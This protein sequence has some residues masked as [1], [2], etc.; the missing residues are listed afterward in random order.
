MCFSGGQIVEKVATML[1][2]CSVISGPRGVSPHLTSPSWTTPTRQHTRQSHC[3]RQLTTDHDVRE[4][5]RCSSSPQPGLR[6]EE[7]NEDIWRRGAASPD[8]Q[9]ET[10]VAVQCPGN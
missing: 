9:G 2:W 10:R 3:A 1:Y 7:R 6:S 5:E 4:T 8:A